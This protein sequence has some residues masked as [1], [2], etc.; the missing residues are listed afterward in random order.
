MYDWR[1]LQ[2]WHISESLLPP[3]STVQFSELR[4]WEKYR[5]Y[6]AA[7]VAALLVQGGLIGWL[8]YEYR[9]RNRAEILARSSIAELTHMNRLATASELSASI[10]HEVSQPVTGIVAYG[11]RRPCATFPGRCPTIKRSMIFW[12]KS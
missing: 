3:G 9:R 7:L 1:Q 8:V 2:R 11:E 6:I 4:L 10:A 5:L 12:S